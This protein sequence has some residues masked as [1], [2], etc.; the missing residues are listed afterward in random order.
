MEIK[1]VKLP[2]R[3]PP[4]LG[5]YVAQ[6]GVDL[7]PDS[8]R[9]LDPEGQWKTI[10]GAIAVAC[11][12]KQQQPFSIFIA[13]EVST[14]LSALGPLLSRIQEPD[15]PDQSVSILGFE[16]AP[17]DE[18][19]KNVEQYHLDYDL[20][21]FRTALDVQPVNAVIIAV[22][23]GEQ[24]D[25]YFQPKLAPSKFEGAVYR[26]DNV[27]AGNRLYRFEAG[28]VAFVTLICS[29]FILKAPNGRKIADV[30]NYE[31][32]QSERAV[33][34]VINVQHNPAPDHA[35]F[36]QAL[37]RLYDADTQH[38]CTLF[39]NSAHHPNG[40]QG[41]S[42]IL[43]P[44][45]R[46]LPPVQ[47]V[48]LIEAPVC[49]YEV[50]HEE[51]LLHIELQSLR[52][53]D[54]STYFP[55]VTRLFA[56]EDGNWK[57]G[58]KE[59]LRFITPSDSPR[60]PS[61]F[62][63]Y[64]TFA[65]RAGDLGDYRKAE[66]WLQAA[67]KKYEEGEDW[68]AAAHA[69]HRL[70][71]Q[72]RH[73]ADYPRAQGAYARGKEL[74]SRI[75]ARSFDVQMLQWKLSLGDALA[76]IYHLQ[77]DIGEMLHIADRTEIE[78]RQYLAQT[79]LPK[80][81]QHKVKTLLLHLLRQTAEMNRLQGDAA[82]AADQFGRAFRQ[83]HWGEAD[84]R[85]Y[86]LL[87]RAESERV[88]QRWTKARR[89]YDDVAEFARG[90]KDVRLQMRADRGLAELC[91]SQDDF[92]GCEQFLEKLE[93]RTRKVTYLFGTIYTHLIRGGLLLQRGDHGGARRQFDDAH[94]LTI[95]DAFELGVEARFAKLGLAE[96]ER[97]AGDDTAIAHYQALANEGCAKKIGW[98]TSLAEQGAKLASDGNR[99]D[100]LFIN[101]P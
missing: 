87:G 56:R 65:E 38:L 48:K 34:F 77:G 53:R 89:H 70:G 66:E 43:F 25:V 90:S 30:L 59:H 37:N 45:N 4:A 93:E 100:V 67:I 82:T 14:P 101:I 74:L 41:N 96:V 22:R 28:N 75:R 55:V 68:F 91:R 10:D 69:C 79:A 36:T 42:R 98:V 58:P 97:M 49:G 78:I 19:Q 44:A 33:D 86:S 29:D 39:A 1:D 26:I 40:V 64:E 88:M 60:L 24:L 27:R 20:D 95:G 21:F 81:Q 57:E 52:T 71:V 47:Q 23:D 6:L 32:Q 11:D 31:L 72:F 54:E 62:L 5:L 17:A 76:G 99:D 35:L 7:D 3:F 51:C 13:P 61:D 92:K 9:L 80:E 50:N 63:T 2:I 85:A 15:Y 73:E 8:G 94:R 12:H 18:W 84:E 16:I 83:Y 46:K